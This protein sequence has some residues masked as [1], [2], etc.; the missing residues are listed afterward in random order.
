MLSSFLH[1]SPKIPY[2]LPLPCSPTHTFL[3]PTPL[4]SSFTQS[5]PHHPSPS[6]LR[7]WSLPIPISSHT[8]SL[9]RL[10]AS[11]PTEARQGSPVRRMDC[12]DMQQI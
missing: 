3:L 6:P 12:T 4:Q 8:S 5:L 7:G 2:P 1:S 9:C 10:G 11:S